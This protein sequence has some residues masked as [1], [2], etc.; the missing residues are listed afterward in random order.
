MQKSN[1]PQST[2]WRLL[3][4]SFL[5]FLGLLCRSFLRVSIV[6]QYFGGAEICSALNV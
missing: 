2:L 1:Q 4:E 6:Q 5:I 3:C